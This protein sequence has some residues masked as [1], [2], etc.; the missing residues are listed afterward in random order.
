[1]L[2]LVAHGDCRP[3]VYVVDSFQMEVV[4]LNLLF[5]SFKPSAR[6]ARCVGKAKIGINQRPKRSHSEMKIPGVFQQQYCLCAQQSVIRDPRPL[7]HA[8]NYAYMG[9]TTVL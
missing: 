7:Q 9:T 1:M 5:S 2:L 3:V 6:E 8:E 4:S